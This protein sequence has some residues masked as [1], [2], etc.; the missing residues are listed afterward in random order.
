MINFYTFEFFI[1]YINII[2]QFMEDVA[3]KFFDNNQPC[4]QEITDCQSLR[5]EY[6]R[7][8]DAIKRQGGCNSCAERNL[9]NGF[10][11]RIKEYLKQ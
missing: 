4:P 1:L 5:D 9:R 6:N 2:I 3:S 11:A 8:L 7:T 10:I